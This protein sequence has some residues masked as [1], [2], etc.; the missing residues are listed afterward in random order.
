MPNSTAVLLM[1][2]KWVPVCRE[3]GAGMRMGSGTVATL[4]E[5]AG[6]DQHNTQLCA[7][8]VCY[9]EL[10]SLENIPQLRN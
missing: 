6:L 4:M 5:Q 1:E 8:T 2:V 10:L 7:C 9:S 3:H